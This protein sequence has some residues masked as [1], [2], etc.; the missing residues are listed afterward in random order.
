MGRDKRGADFAPFLS[1]SQQ[2]AEMLLENVCRANGSRGPRACEQ[3]HYRMEQWVG[4]NTGEAGVAQKVPVAR[5]TYC[6]WS[7]G[8]S[9]AITWAHSI[10][11]CGFRG[12]FP[13][14]FAPSGLVTPRRFH[15]CK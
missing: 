7:N 10:L 9:V 6:Y 14:H 11:G 3:E 2:E 8:Q 12:G 4:R 1:D 13:A 15:A 5:K